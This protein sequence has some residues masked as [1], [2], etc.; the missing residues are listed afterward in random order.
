MN[1]NSVAIAA[2][3]PTLLAGSAVKGQSRVG[4]GLCQ[5]G[6]TSVR[7]VQL[8]RL[9]RPRLAAG[10]RPPRP[11]HHDSSEIVLPWPPGGADCRPAKI[12]LCIVGP[13]LYGG[14]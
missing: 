14:Q 13:V 4:G 9:L 10:W 5:P 1:A 7:K 2:P 8:D 6:G 11:R 12:E 3:A